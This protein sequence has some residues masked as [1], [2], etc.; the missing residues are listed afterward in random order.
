AKTS[1]TAS[2]KT[3]KSA[4]KTSISNEDTQST[5]VK[6]SKTEKTFKAPFTFLYTKDNK[7]LKTP[8]FR[9]IIESEDRANKA[10]AGGEVKG[11][12]KPTLSVRRKTSLAEETSEELLER[13]LQ[14]LEEENNSHRFQERNQICTKCCVNIVAPEYRVDKDMGYCEE[15]A[16][17][18][19]LGF[20]KE[21]RHVQ[22]NIKKSTDNDDL[23]DVEPSEEDLEDMDLDED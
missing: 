18:L 4:E 6:S 21:A 1:K 13:I 2:S 11:L 7:L 23:D 8:F 14:E 16:A 15:C 10:K 5:K 12:A 20:S 3:T 22:Y 19:G 9:E 17:I